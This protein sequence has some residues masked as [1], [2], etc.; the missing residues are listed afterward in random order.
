MNSVRR[1]R[2]DNRF[3]L[4]LFACVNKESIGIF[5]E[6]GLVDSMVNDSE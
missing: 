4:V 2:Y 5:V 6:V 1:D 3:G